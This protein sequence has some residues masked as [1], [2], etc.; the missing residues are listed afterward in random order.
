MHIL[1][2]YLHNYADNCCQLLTDFPQSL[3]YESV[4]VVPCYD[5]PRN[6]IESVTTKLTSKQKHLLIIVINQPDSDVR[7]EPQFQLAQHLKQQGKMDWSNDGLCLVKTGQCFD[8][9]LVDRYSKQKIPIKEGVGRARKIGLDLACTLFYRDQIESYWLGSTDADV[10]LPEN[11]LSLLQELSQHQSNQFSAALLDF[12]HIQDKGHPLQEDIFECT[13]IY[14]KALKYFV[15]GLRFADSQYDYQSIGSITILNSFDYARVRGIPVRAAGE[16]FYL[17]NKMAKTGPILN[18]E[19]HKVEILSRKSSRVP[20]GTGPMVEKIMALKDKMAFEY[21]H[22]QGFKRLKILL[23]SLQMM[24]E[25][26]DLDINWQ[27]GLSESDC[28]AMSA[29]NFDRFYERLKSQNHSLKQRSRQLKEWF[30]AFKTLKY[31]NW[32]RDHELGT[33][34]LHKAL[35]DPVEKLP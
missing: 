7:V 6:C 8:Y 27:N 4:I 13:R 18:L 11:Y 1:G 31:L 28:K 12:E 35:N 26:K 3:K 22:P 29:L 16:D 24:I 2:K 23:S 15:N 9:L 10:I 33:M 21:Y 14:E 20:F 30:D 32:L 5:E 25:D 17:L 19:K 34:P